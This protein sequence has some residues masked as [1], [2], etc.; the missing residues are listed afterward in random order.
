MQNDPIHAILQKKKI[1][2]ELHVLAH[3]VEENFSKKSENFPLFPKTRKF[4]KFI[5]SGL[6]LDKV[7]AKIFSQKMGIQVEGI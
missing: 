3:S 2:S 4:G 6:Q 5:Y 1:I 7:S